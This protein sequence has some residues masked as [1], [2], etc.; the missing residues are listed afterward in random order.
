MS[1]PSD[2]RLSLLELSYLV[3][4]LLRLYRA[5]PQAKVLDFL[6]PEIERLCVVGD[7][8]LTQAHAVLDADEH[9]GFTLEHQPPIHAPSPEVP[10]WLHV[11][12]PQMESPL[13]VKSFRP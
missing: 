2:L 4:R 5:R 10:H 7:L 6:D 9:S 11:R 8:T 3:A 12:R 1:A 13:R